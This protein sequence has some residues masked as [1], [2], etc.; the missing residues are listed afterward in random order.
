MRRRHSRLRR[1]TAGALALLLAALGLAAPAQA[2]DRQALLRAFGDAAFSYL[3]GEKEERLLK[4]EGELRIAGLGTPS[5]AMTQAV[6][7]LSDGIQSA[8]GLPMGYTEEEVS[9]LFAFTNRPEQDLTGKWARYAEPFFESDALFRQGAA[10]LEGPDA[11]PCLAKLVVLERAIRAALIVVRSDAPD[12]EAV[13]CLAH[14][15]LGAL[16][17][18]RTAALPPD[19]LLKQPT[20][21]FAPGRAVEPSDSDRALLWLLYHKDMPHAV[22]RDEGMA[23]AELLLDDVPGLE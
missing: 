21:A 6:E 16:G 18:I 9:L 3:P 1:R 7:G 20:A 13:Q 11:P 23:I 14:E 4:W 12:A 5:R 2:V 8:T 17:L 10:A 15:Y 19:S 22:P